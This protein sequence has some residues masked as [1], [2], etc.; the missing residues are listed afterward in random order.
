MILGVLLILLFI[1]NL[2]IIYMQCKEFL[3]KGF[4]CKGNALENIV[5][6]YGE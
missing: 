5:V 1:H 2:C 6:R 4:F 3:C